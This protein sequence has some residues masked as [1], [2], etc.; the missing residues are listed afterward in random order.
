M[1]TACRLHCWNGR[2]PS[3][4][5]CQYQF[6]HTSERPS[7]LVF[8]LQTESLTHVL[9]TSLSAPLFRS[10]LRADPLSRCAALGLPNHSIA[11]LPFYQSQAELDIMDVDSPTR[12]VPYSPSYILN[13]SAQVNQDIRHVIDFVFL[14]GFNNPTLAVLYQTEQT[15]TG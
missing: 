10:E 2:T 5:S 8:P 1:L 15:W 4:T 3:T 13:L 9:Q 14:P 6:I 7:W 11:I 12:D